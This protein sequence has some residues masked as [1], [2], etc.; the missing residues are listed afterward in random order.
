M[1]RLLSVATAD[2]GAGHGGSARYSKE[3]IHSETPAMADW[4]EHAVDP[5]TNRDGS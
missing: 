3:K 5:R 4:Q 1:Y 2:I